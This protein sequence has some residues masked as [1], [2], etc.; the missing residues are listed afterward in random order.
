MNCGDRE[1]EREGRRGKAKRGDDAIGKWH[2]GPVVM[3]TTDF[4]QNVRD[5]FIG[6]YPHSFFSAG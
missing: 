2:Y 6:L 5:A 4:A 1:R 3:G